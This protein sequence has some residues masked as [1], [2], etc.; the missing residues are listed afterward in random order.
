MYSFLLGINVFGW[1]RA[2]VNHILIFEINPRKNL[3]YSHML[4]LHGIFGVIWSLSV[5]GFIYAED[6]HV[7]RSLFP[8]L[9]LCIMLGFLLN[10]LPIFHQ[11]ARF[12]FLRLL[13]RLV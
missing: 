7:A 1:R 13:V 6:M 9:L 5:L 8:L 2:G 12:W 3:T 4:E 11:N 10:P